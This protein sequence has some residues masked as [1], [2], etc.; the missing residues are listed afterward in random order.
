M[1]IVEESSYQKEKGELKNENLVLK[2]KKKPELTLL[3]V[4]EMAEEDDHFQI[5]EEKLAKKF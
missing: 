1:N 4:E 2:K 5:Y 3:D